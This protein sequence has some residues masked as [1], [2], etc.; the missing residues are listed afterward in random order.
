MR[1]LVLADC[2][3][4]PEL[5][6]NALN[7]ASYCKGEDVLVFAGDI[8][9]IGYHAEECLNILEDNSAELLWGNHDWAAINEHPIHPQNSYDEDFLERLRKIDF[10]IACSYNNI[11][12]TH[13]GLS[14]DFYEKIGKMGV[15]EVVRIAN[16]LNTR[17]VYN[18][19]SGLLWYRPSQLNPPAPFWQISGHTPPGYMKY[20][21][22]R[23]PFK[24]FIMIDPYINEGFEKKGRFRYVEIADGIKIFDSEE[25]LDRS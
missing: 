16:S 19:R 6:T 24:K 17:G 12:I 4:R 23:K 5:I 11:L 18:E 8:V 22:D 10:K 9:D 7:H 25:N 3:G 2:H 21:K 1:I 20:I 15:R 13:A 14:M